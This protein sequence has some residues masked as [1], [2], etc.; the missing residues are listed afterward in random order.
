M[1]KQMESLVVST[2]NGLV[3]I[4]QS[5]HGEDAGIAINPEQ[6]PLLIEWLNEAVAELATA[7]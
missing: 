2:K 3:W 7:S 5:A 4:E 1:E 6:V